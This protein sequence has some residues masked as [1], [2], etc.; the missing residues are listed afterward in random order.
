M[1]ET[2]TLIEAYK[3]FGARLLSE[4]VRDGDRFGE[5]LMSSTT[6]QQMSTL[7]FVNVTD[8]DDRVWQPV[9]A[10]GGVCVAY[11]LVDRFARTLKQAHNGPGLTVQIELLELLIEKEQQLGVVC[12][13]FEET[14][15][16][17]GCKYDNEAALVALDDLQQL[18]KESKTRNQALEYQLNELQ[19]HKQVI[20]SERNAALEKLDKLGQIGP[21]PVP[22]RDARDDEIAE[23]TIAVRA[24][25]KTVV[26]LCRLIVKDDVPQPT[27]VKEDE[28]G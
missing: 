9:F 11:Q 26:V 14:C 16:A 15:D 21:A 22:T 10:D 20:V 6:R 2:I 23:L 1:N 18:V 28:H 17:L 27:H 24:Y 13:T 3:R 7:R 12:K 25:E 8:D 5:R 19:T 4:R